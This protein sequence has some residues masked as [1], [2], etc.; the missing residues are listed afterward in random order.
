MFTV[1]GL[2]VFA[3]EPLPLS[4]PLLT[5]PNL[6]L[7]PH[8]AGRTL[9]VGSRIWRDACDTLVAIAELPEKGGVS[10]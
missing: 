9:Q 7:T 4:S 6:L 2:D 5:A 10:A 3:T 1:S 8:V